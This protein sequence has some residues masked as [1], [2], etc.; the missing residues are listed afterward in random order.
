MLTIAAFYNEAIG[1]AVGKL[2]GIIL[3]TT[4][5]SGFVVRPATPSAGVRLGAEC[6]MVAVRPAAPR[7]PKPFIS[8]RR[9]H[10]L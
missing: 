8:L 4:Y 6:R 10:R 2:F 7:H 9:L 1:E 5:L 3:G